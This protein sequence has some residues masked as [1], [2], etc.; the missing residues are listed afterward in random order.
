MIFGDHKITLIGGNTALIGDI[1]INANYTAAG[2]VVLDLS[3]TTSVDGSAINSLT[4]NL[5]NPGNTVMSSN[6][7][8]IMLKAPVGGLNIK[9]GVTPTLTSPAGWELSNTYG[10]LVYRPASYSSSFDTS[11]NNII[12]NMTYLPFPPADATAE[13]VEAAAKCIASNFPSSNTNETNSI[14]I[15]GGNVNTPDAVAIFVQNVLKV[16]DTPSLREGAAGYIAQIKNAHPDAQISK[17][18]GL[19]L[20][21]IMNADGRL[22]PKLADAVLNQDTSNISPKLVQ[23]ILSAAADGGV[24]AREFLAKLN[25]ATDQLSNILLNTADSRMNFANIPISNG[26][27]VPT[28]TAF[29]DN[30]NTT[31]TAG[32]IG[33]GGTRS[34]NNNTPE[35]NNSSSLR[36]EE[37]IYGDDLQA[38]S[39]GVASGSSPYDRFG[40]WGSINTGVGR[41]KQRK[42]ISGFNSVYQG[43]AIGVDTMVND[44]ASVGFMLSHTR[45]YI[46]H[47]DENR[48]GATSWVGAI[49]GNRRLK[50]DWF[51]RG[52][53]MFNKTHINQKELRNIRNGLGIAQAKYNLVSYGGEASIGFTHKF[54]NQIVLTPTIG[55][56]MLHNNKISYD[57][58]GDTGQNNKIAQ[59]AMDNYS[60]LAGLSLEKTIVRSGID[61]TPEANANIQCGVNTKS[62]RGSFVSPL[63]PNIRSDFIGAKPSQISANY[64]VSLTGSGERVECGVSGTMSVADKYRG[65]TGSLKL[66][67]KF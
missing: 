1:I 24:T 17:P 57:Q 44:K 36:K 11:S 2:Q 41:Q 42:N 47:K 66:K 26:S 9:G 64:G 48:T 8:V 40:V 65:Y 21:A 33:A 6:D 34:G 25:A 45:N 5:T 60:A 27:L 35:R 19:A 56:R 52:I 55:V 43:L 3:G 20:A 23:T 12:Q 29:M 18:T 4:F 16:L 32:E 49:Y 58:T 39:A 63:N 46:K 51:I 53:G 54:K 28:Q 22:P 15:F 13:E 62:P 31:T 50:N 30:E 61:F 38:V 59:N 67:V 37:D 7:S 14:D 10:T